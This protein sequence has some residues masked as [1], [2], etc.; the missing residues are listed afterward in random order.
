MSICGARNVLD[1]TILGMLFAGLPAWQHLHT[2]V[3][4]VSKIDCA[5]RYR[6]WR[7]KPNS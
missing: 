3:W 2:T 4:P 6:F 1:I 5:A 7:K